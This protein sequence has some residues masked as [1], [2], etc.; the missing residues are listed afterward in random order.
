[1]T[2]MPSQLDR[3]AGSVIWGDV[4][5]ACSQPATK[6][7][8]DLSCSF[9]SQVSRELLTS[10][11]YADWP[12]LVALGYFSRRANLERMREHALSSSREIRLGRGVV[13]HIAPANV[14]VNFAYSF[15]FGML[16]GNANI[17]RLPSR[18][19]S[20]VDELVAIFTRLFRTT[21][22]VEIG[23]KAVFVR[24]PSDDEAV[25]AELSS[26]ADAR[27]VWGGDG[28]VQALRRYSISPRCVDVNFSDRYSFCALDADAI[29]RLTDKE[30]ER[31]AHDFYNDSYLF[32]QGACSSPRLV[33][34]RAAAQYSIARA[35][36]RFWRAV[37]QR[38][39]SAY[40]LS[41]VD[42]VGKFSGLCA[43]LIKLGS[44]AKVIINSNLLYI[45]D[46][47]RVPNI[48]D[49]LDGRFGTFYECIVEDLR[50][51]RGFVT[52]R[53][54]TLSYFGFSKEEL[55]LFVL[56]AGMRGL[57]RVVPVGRALSMSENWDGYDI[58]LPRYFWSR[59]NVHKRDRG[60]GGWRSRD[61]RPRRSFISF[62][63]RIC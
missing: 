43:S 61:T 34:W 5:A 60:R 37:R 7:F 38:V 57:D 10:R 23:R 62:G 29:A 35:K 55:K 27:V 19:F 6:P 3:Y 18:D 39:E 54:Q 25:T 1:M 53:F 8:C 28:T 20:Q 12:E 15:F 56:G 31:L 13:L 16:A 14:P 63:R 2:L 32:D 49:E 50:D 44:G 41:A 52:P 36:E 51:L 59:F 47:G 9:V 21:D 48:P 17:I 45:V 42:A 30:L 24:Y 33:V 46:I 4:A 26:V 11:R 40:S 58:D 22:Y